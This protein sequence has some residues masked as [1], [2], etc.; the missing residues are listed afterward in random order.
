M[1]G[2]SFLQLARVRDACAE[3]L[4]TKLAPMNVL[5]VQNFADTLGCASLVTACDKYVQKFFSHVVESE[6]F[7]GLSYKQVRE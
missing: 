5:G 6:E 2:A 4:M 1:M 7:L 3:F